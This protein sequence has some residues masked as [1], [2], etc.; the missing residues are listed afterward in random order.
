M[1]KTF[2]R[3]TDGMP[4]QDAVTAYRTL[5]DAEH[6]ALTAQHLD[7]TVLR[8]AYLVAGAARDWHT[9]GIALTEAR[10]RSE[11]RRDSPAAMA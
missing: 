8:R 7:L 6:P 5:L 11:V 9:Q 3:R 1:R 4:D 2:V 10:R